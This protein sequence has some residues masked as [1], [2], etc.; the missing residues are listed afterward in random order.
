MRGRMAGMSEVFIRYAVVAGLTVALLYHFGL[1]AW[2]VAP[3]RFSLKGMLATMTLVALI[4]G[5]AVY[6]AR[7]SARS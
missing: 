5:L 1:L 7:H 4:L 3:K 6:L 2:I